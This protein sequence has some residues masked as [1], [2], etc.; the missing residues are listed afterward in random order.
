M[1]VIEESFKLSVQEWDIEA[2][3]YLCLTIPSRYLLVTENQ[4]E[5]ITNW[6]KHH[7]TN[8]YLNSIPNIH[9]FVSATLG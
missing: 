8:E 7:C 1:E 5:R 6:A 3:I 4:I 9:S 2:A